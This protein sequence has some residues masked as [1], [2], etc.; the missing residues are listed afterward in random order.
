MTDEV[1]RDEASMLFALAHAPTVPSLVPA[2]EVRDVI[3]LF[4]SDT[5][6]LAAMDPN[7]TAEGHEH[8]GSKMH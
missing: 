7:S 2:Q 1:F 5:A 3:V 6:A 8:L 4:C